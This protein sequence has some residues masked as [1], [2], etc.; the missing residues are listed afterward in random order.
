MSWRSGANETRVNDVLPQ[1]CSAPHLT[2][3]REPMALTLG[4]ALGLAVARQHAQGLRV[5]LHERDYR[6]ECLLADCR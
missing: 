5:Q 6:G 4:L 3:T 1:R 2:Q